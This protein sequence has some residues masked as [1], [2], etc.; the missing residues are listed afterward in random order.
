MYVQITAMLFMR[1]V[2]VGPKGVQ[3]ICLIELLVSCRS[4]C[5]EI[6]YKFEIVWVG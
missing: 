6:L 1:S 4:C 3:D 2:S 5:V